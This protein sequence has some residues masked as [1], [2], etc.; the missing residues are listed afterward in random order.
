[1]LKGTRAKLELQ[2]GEPL[3][4]GL[5]ERWLCDR[6]RELAWRGWS[7]LVQHVERSTVPIGGH[8]EVSRPGLPEWCGQRGVGTPAA[9]LNPRFRTFGAVGNWG[10]VPAL[11][12]TRHPYRCV[13]SPPVRVPQSFSPINGQDLWSGL[14]A[15]KIISRVQLN[16]T[17]PARS[18]SGIE[19]W[20]C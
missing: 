7:D 13:S 14:W 1:M 17:V 15:V 8:R 19:I 2:A 5:P 16:V 4:Q 11:P 10:E 6:A 18:L 9:R 3:A 20:G 12:P